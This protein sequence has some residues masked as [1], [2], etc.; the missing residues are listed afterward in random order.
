MVET[1][2]SQQTVDEDRTDV[3]NRL[4]EFPHLLEEIFM[5]LNIATLLQVECTTPLVLQM[6]PT[7]IWERIWQRN[8][9]VSP[10]WK[11]LTARLEHTDPQLFIG[12]KKG[13]ICSFRRACCRVQQSIEQILRYDV[14]DQ[15][16]LGQFA[17]NAG[18]QVDERN[19]YV[20]CGSKITVINRWTRQIVK[21]L[22][23]DCIVH[24]MLVRDGFIFLEFYDSRL[25]IFDIH[26]YKEIQTLRVTNDYPFLEGICFQHGFLAVVTMSRN[27]KS[28]MVTTRR[29]NASTK[30][31]G[32]DIEN[33]TIIENFGFGLWMWTTRAYLDHKFLIIDTYRADRSMRVT[34]VMDAKSLKQLTQRTFNT[35]H[36][37]SDTIKEECHNGV[38][39]V[40]NDSKEGCYLAAWDVEK[41]TIQPISNLPQ[42]SKEH[43]IIASAAVAINPNC[44]FMLSVRHF[45]PVNFHVLSVEEW[46][47]VDDSL[48]LKD[49]NS[50]IG[51]HQIKEWSWRKDPFYFDGVQLLWCGGDYLNVI[52][53]LPTPNIQNL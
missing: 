28:L 18:F 33:S 39:I 14:K 46:R 45:E 37:F 15:Y 40:Q 35:A 47:R 3:L 11:L 42:L 10:T 20:Y 29:W 52:D 8:V 25:S 23:L 36:I 27:M 41:D 16:Q 7:S 6:T 1:E 21:E 5:T 4:K 2:G 49:F 9:M 30:Q 32:P 13:S 17:T 22:Y 34:K 26:S 51:P 44:Q 38:M 12:M 24:D 31:F 53:F 43:I 48:A 50:E 19:V